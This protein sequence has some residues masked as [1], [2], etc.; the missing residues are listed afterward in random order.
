[1]CFFFLLRNPFSKKVNRHWFFLCLFSYTDNKYISFLL[2]GINT[3]NKIQRYNSSTQGGRL[4]D[5]RVLQNQCWTAWTEHE[6]NEMF[7]GIN[8]SGW[9][10][11]KMSFCS[12]TLCTLHLTLF[13]KSILWRQNI[14]AGPCARTETRK[15]RATPIQFPLNN[16]HFGEGVDFW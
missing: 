7:S 8:W 11:D 1:M 3:L 9:R 6:E 10:C 14:S 4:G 16:W 5:L 15:G 2:K 12:S 13:A